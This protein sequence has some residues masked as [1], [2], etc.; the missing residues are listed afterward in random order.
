MNSSILDSSKSLLAHESLSKRLSGRLKSQSPE[1]QL[2]GVPS[3]DNFGTSI[4]IA[5][6]N[7]SMN[8]K[9]DRR[10]TNLSILECSY[11]DTTKIAN[12]MCVS[13]GNSSGQNSQAEALSTLNP[14]KIDR[15]RR[16]SSSSIDLKLSKRVKTIMHQKSRLPNGQ[17]V[18][19]IE[20]N[21]RP[22]KFILTS[23]DDSSSSQ[24]K[25]EQDI[26]ALQSTASLQN[27]TLS[28][29]TT[30]AKSV[31]PSSGWNPGILLPQI[32]KSTRVTETTRLTHLHERWNPSKHTANGLNCDSSKF[33]HIHR[34]TPASIL[35]SGSQTNGNENASSTRGATPWHHRDQ[36]VRRIQNRPETAEKIDTCNL[37]STKRQLPNLAPM[38]SRP[39][40]KHRSASPQFNSN[41][42][43]SLAAKRENVKSR[44]SSDVPSSST[45]VPKLSDQQVLKNENHNRRFS[46][47][48]I[49]SSTKS[50]PLISSAN[51]SSKQTT[52]SVSSNR[53]T[54]LGTNR[55][56]PNKAGEKLHP[57][58]VHSTKGRSDNAVTPSEQRKPSNMGERKIKDGNEK[59]I[60]QS[61]RLSG[62]LSS[63]CSKRMSDVNDNLKRQSNSSARLQNTFKKEFKKR[64]E[65]IDLTEFFGG[66]VEQDLLACISLSKSGSV[67][68]SKKTRT[69]DISSLVPSIKPVVKSETSLSHLSE[70]ER[71]NISH[72][73]EHKTSEQ[74]LSCGELTSHNDDVA[75][76]AIPA[77]AITRNG[78]HSYQRSAILS[79]PS[80]IVIDLTGDD[81]ELVEIEIDASN[82]NTPTGEK[83]S[84]S[85]QIAKSNEKL[86]NEISSEDSFDRIISTSQNSMAIDFE[87]FP[88]DESIS[89]PHVS[90]VKQNKDGMLDELT[91]KIT[92]T[93]LQSP[94]SAT[95]SGTID[96]LDPSKQSRPSEPTSTTE[97][98]RNFT[99]KQHD[100]S[101]TRQIRNED[102]HDRVD[103]DFWLLQPNRED[104]MNLDPNL[105]KILDDD[106]SQNSALPYPVCAT[107]RSTHFR[108]RNTWR[109]SPKKPVEQSK[110]PFVFTVPPVCSTYPPPTFNPRQFS[111]R[112]EITGTWKSVIERKGTKLKIV[113]YE[114]KQK[115]EE[116]EQ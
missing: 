72:K 24:K 23:E 83:G 28:N 44:S 111:I 81:A 58:I 110:D 18:L 68:R 102:T 77:T 54:D 20:D 16:L 61:S 36:N 29:Q 101:T 7:V 14:S 48:I 107:E 116:E 115:C 49:H 98:G 112:R 5:W 96:R 9:N 76:D 100:N 70:A 1:L 53:R 51:V 45:K 21:I 71:R 15:K 35:C 33:S 91:T 97:E 50:Y 67:S 89:I 80:R 82:C 79:E 85:P 52:P 59:S 55:R 8:I 47:A 43:S 94:V 3:E 90:N 37:S 39:Y 32:F 93:T 95:N 46:S 69:S 113:G 22:A 106:L 99:G 42:S 11:H 108:V 74:W 12:Q 114:K 38:H 78:D 105:L 56:F 17:D 4:D 27:T 88:S 109:S 41:T 40:P 30:G 25:T 6:D 104:V 34:G 86:G 10:F 64:N 63:K 103:D 57:D 31:L 84:A 62:S 73:S 19:T 75:T 26:N 66:L 92:K 87:E 13:D 65:I 2:D 60:S